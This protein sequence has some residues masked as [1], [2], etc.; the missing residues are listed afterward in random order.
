MSKYESEK[1]EAAIKYDNLET[2]ATSGT[3]GTEQGQ[4]TES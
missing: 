1:P 4:N 2:Q 3:Q